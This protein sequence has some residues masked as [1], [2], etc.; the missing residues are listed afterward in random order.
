MATFKFYNVELLPRD[1][2]QI[3]PAG[4]RGY[5]T[6]LRSVSDLS[7]QAIKDRALPRISASLRNEMLF[8]PFSVNIEQSYAWGKFV[9][10]SDADSIKDLYTGAVEYDLKPYQTSHR[11]EFFFLFDY[12][13]HTLVVQDK[14]RLPS[15]RPLE[16]ALHSIFSLPDETFLADY[17]LRVREITSCEDIEGLLDCADGFR[18]ARIEV[19][20]SNSDEF[21]DAMTDDIESELREKNIHDV[22]HVEKSDKDS[23]ITSLSNFGLG[24]LFLAYAHG[25]ADLSYVQDGQRKTY[26]MKDHPVRI[27]VK[28][29]KGATIED[30]LPEIKQL[31][32]KAHEQARIGEHVRARLSEKRQAHSGDK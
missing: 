30:R 13:R 15:R 4:Q 23:L 10:F 22:E 5:R 16:L 6:L 28:P 24:L 9:R 29:K 11:D 3:D 32:P 31:V 27:Q 19:S 14:P 25:D 1:S 7:S 26:H 21:D 18:K 8:A 2:K 20:F 12:Q 17:T